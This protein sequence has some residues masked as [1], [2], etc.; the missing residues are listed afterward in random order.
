MKYSAASRCFLGHRR[1]WEEAIKIDGY[2]LICEADFVPCKRLGNLPVFW[3]VD[4]PLAWGYL[5]QGSPRLLA[6][7]EG[8]F[9]RAHVT[10]TVAYVINRMVAEILLE[11]YEEELT[12]YSLKEYFTFEAHLQWWSM[13]RGAE[14]YIPIALS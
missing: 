8:R 9:L 7:C 4:R 1:A 11:F 13:G 2:S 5:Y 12:H 3:P 6:I 14:A 10:P